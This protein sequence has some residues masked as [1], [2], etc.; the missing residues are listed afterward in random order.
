[1]TKKYII[2]DFFRV[3]YIGQNGWWVSSRLDARLFDSMEDATQLIGT[4]SSENAY[5]IIEVLYV[6]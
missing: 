2:H 6:S 5:Q 1:M 4:F 3:M